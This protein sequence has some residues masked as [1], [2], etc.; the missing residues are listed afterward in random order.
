MEQPL[1]LDAKN[2]NTLWVD[3]ISKDLENITVAF[4]ILPAGK[5]APIGHQLMQC[6][7]VF[8]I[9]T[10]DFRQQTRLVAGGHMIKA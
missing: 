2:G 8:Y 7:M 10:E 4:E 3:A 9:K 5:K 1:A 6:H